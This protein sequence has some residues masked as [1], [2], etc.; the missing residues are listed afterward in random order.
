MRV[1]VCEHKC[2]FFIQLLSKE[3]FVNLSKFNHLK[4]SSTKFLEDL[5][6]VESNVYMLAMHCIAVAYNEASI[7][8]S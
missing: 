2:I 1:F 3:T 7:F 6:I 4:C 5:L 8:T